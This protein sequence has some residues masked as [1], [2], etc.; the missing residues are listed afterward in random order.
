MM[1]PRPYG[2]TRF[3]E[4][5]SWV[6][7]HNKIS[8]FVSCKVLATLCH[9]QKDCKNQKL[10]RRVVKCKLVDNISIR[11]SGQLWTIISKKKSIFSSMLEWRLLCL[12][13]EW[14]CLVCMEMN[15]S[16]ARQ[17]GGENSGGPPLTT[18]LF[19]ILDSMMTP[20]GSDGES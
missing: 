10:G 3:P 15:L 13:Y 6:L 12:T 4:C 2:Y 8:Y 18:E 16:T 20:S 19:S 17:K 11:N 9:K 1:Q 7:S 14:L 5:G